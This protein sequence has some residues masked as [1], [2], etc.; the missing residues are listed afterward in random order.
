MEEQFSCAAAPGSIDK[1]ERLG[2]IP[3]VKVVRRE[4]VVPL[5]LAGLGIERDNAIGIKIVSFALGAVIFGVGIT[6]LPIDDAEFFI[7]GASEPGDR[8]AVLA[9]I[10]FPGLRSGLVSRRH[11]PESPHLL[12][13]CDGIGSQESTRAL[14]ATGRTGNHQIARYQRRGSCVIVLAPVGHLGVPFEV[15]GVAI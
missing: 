10:A 3:I 13:G 9:R 1:N 2:G 5:Q 14:F 6:G 8:A 4:L 11:S 7:I 15:P 12:S